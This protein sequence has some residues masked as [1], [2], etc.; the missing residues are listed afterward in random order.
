MWIDAEFIMREPINLCP[1]I[2]VRAAGRESPRVFIPLFYLHVKVVV[3][4][5]G[6]C[7]GWAAERCC[8]CLPHAFYLLSASPTVW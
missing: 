6:S 5:A 1:V 3:F 7:S 8:V 4:C 2:Y